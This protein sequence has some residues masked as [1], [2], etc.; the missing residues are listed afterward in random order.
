MMSKSQFKPF[1]RNLRRYFDAYGGWPDVLGSP[2]FLS[3]LFISA[4]SYR[5]WLKPEWTDAAYAL[6]PSLLGFSLG[7]YALLFS[8]ITSRVKSA[9]RAV[10][11]ENAVSALEQVNAIFF[12]FI[13]VQVLGLL[14]AFGFDGSLLA[15]L[16]AWMRPDMPFIWTIFLAFKAAGAFIGFLL[17]IYSVALVG[18]AALAIYRLAL[19][20]DPADSN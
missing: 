7:T 14:W 16:S 1:I 11:N 2:L 10:K 15:D 20:S 3:S 13:F 4:V 6:L 12:H 8:L 5:Q 17:M 9:L 18:G 19:I